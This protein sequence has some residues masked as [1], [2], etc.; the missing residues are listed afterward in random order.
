MTLTEKQLKYVGFM[1]P[2]TK[3]VPDPWFR[4]SLLGL[5]MQHV[6]KFHAAFRIT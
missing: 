6:H 3:K 5:Y 2:L 1:A 4:L